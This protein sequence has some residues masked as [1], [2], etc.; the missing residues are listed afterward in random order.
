MARLRGPSFGLRIALARLALRI[1]V[2][3]LRLSDFRA[4]RDVF[5]RSEGLIGG[6][7]SELAGAVLGRHFE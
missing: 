7:G 3:G 6:F 1:S 5:F 4:Q 2:L